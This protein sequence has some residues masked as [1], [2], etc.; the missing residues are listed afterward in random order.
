MS[1]ALTACES[2]RDI[3]NRLGKD[4]S[5][6]G[7][8][9]AFTGRLVSL[10]KVEAADLVIRCGGRPHRTVT[11]RTTMLVVGQEGWPLQSDGQLTGNLR[12]ALT[13]IHDGRR[14]KVVTEEQWLRRLSK[15]PE[16]AH[17]RR[18]L[19]LADLHRLLN[20]P[21]DRLRGW[22]RAGLLTA[23][24]RVNGVPYFNFRQ[25]S[26]VRNLCELVRRGVTTDQLK[27]SFRQL[28]TWMAEATHSLALLEHDGRLLVR[29]RDNL[30]AEPAGQLCWDFS[31][32]PCVTVTLSRPIPSQ[33]EWFE[34]GWSFEQDEQLDQAIHAYRQ[35]LIAGKP[36]AQICVNLGNALHAAG[37]CG[38]AIESYRQAVE[39]EPDSAEAWNNLGVTLAENSDHNGAISALQRSIAL[40][41]A[42]V[43][44]CFN[45]A[46][47]FTDLHRPQAALP[48]WR[49]CIELDP[50]SQWADY[51]RKQIA[52]IGSA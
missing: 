14:M 18:L 31:E 25:A 34:R 16:L 6:A 51:A 33:Q 52:A 50:V 37:H 20:V 45:L 26:G 23:A 3:S 39:L 29:L 40:D 12:R 22:M 1:H 4:A 9:V 35:A 19:S 46:D 43:D 27:R 30:L 28:Q 42:Y 24:C 2:R 11:H 5:L 17:V 44:P 13:L 48:L 36:Q 8:S 21:R 7:E 10:T 49:R 47:L 41:P 15:Q 38:D 32:E